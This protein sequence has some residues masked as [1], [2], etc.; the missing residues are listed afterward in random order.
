M[1]VSIVR[2]VS[3]ECNRVI[4]YLHSSQLLGLTLYMFLTVTVCDALISLSLISPALCQSYV[5]HILT[6]CLAQLNNTE[7]YFTQVIFSF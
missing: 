3:G 7:F 5:L 6:D 4:S 2:S 1:C